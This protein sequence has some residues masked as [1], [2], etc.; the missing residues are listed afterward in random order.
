MTEEAM[1]S[2]T[3]T[4]ET[5]ASSDTVWAAIVALHSGTP[6][7]PDS[8]SFE[9]HGPFELGTT[10]TITPQGQEPVQSTITELVPGKVYADETV[11]GDVLLTFRH[12]LISLETGGT[13]VSH[14][15]EIGGPDGDHV[16]PELGPQISSDFPLA[17]SELLAAA[18]RWPDIVSS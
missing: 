14:T 16:G 4:A 15:L 13:R 8:D 10:L 6:I 9:L 17:M 5:L 2:T 1:W 7:G 3:H 18:E 11:L 12:T